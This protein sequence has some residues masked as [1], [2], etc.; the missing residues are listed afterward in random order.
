LAIPAIVHVRLEGDDANV[1][2]EH[3][4]AVVPRLLARRNIEL[5][6]TADDGL[7]GLVLRDVPFRIEPERDAGAIGELL[8]DRP[9]VQIGANLRPRFHQHSHALGEHLTRLAERIFDLESTF[10]HAA[11][12]RFDYAAR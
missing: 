9:I 4:V 6:D 7:H 2:R 1:L 11:V 5:V 12:R 3:G 8:P 10:F